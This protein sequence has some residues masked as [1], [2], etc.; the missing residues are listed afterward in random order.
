[1]VYLT[2][3]PCNGSMPFYPQEW[4]LKT[5]EMLTLPNKIV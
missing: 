2:F 3:Y 1:M 5:G 4:D